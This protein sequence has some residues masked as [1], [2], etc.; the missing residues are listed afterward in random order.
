M[1]EPV[2]EQARRVV[3]DL[4]P[5]SEMYPII[6]IEDNTV[7]LFWDF[8]GAALEIG[9]DSHGPYYIRYLSETTLIVSHNRETIRKYLKDL[10]GVL[11]D[12]KRIE[13][14]KGDIEYDLKGDK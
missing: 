14:V 3:R 6:N 5:P 8:D 10:F 7:D 4:N 1:T 2:M 12:N 13:K 9:V 11:V